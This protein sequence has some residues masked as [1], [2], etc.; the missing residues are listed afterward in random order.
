MDK[1]YKKEDL[2]R[3]LDL[4]EQGYS[5]SEAL[6]VIPLNKSILAREMRKRKNLKAEKNIAQYHERSTEE[7]LQDWDMK[8]TQ[9]EQL[10]NCKNKGTT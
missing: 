8:G 5:F 10:Q 2:E 7:I 4:V 3:A 6:K 9:Y 1:K